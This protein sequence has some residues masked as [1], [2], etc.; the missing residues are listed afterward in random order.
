MPAAEATTSLPSVLPLLGTYRS[1][2]V[3]VMPSIGLQ[4]PL[5]LTGEGQPEIR[6]CP[7][8]WAIAGDNGATEHRS[9]VMIIVA[10][11]NDEFLYA[12]S[13][14]VD[15]SRRDNLHF[16]HVSSS[17]LRYF[18]LYKSSLDRVARLQSLHF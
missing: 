10:V 1:F 3:G 15:H 6:P 9:E 17:L 2:I 13:R 11:I 7:G 5:L 4:L 12:V 8:V 18:L 16:V 14:V